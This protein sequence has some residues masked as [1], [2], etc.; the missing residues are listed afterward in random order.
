LTTTGELSG[1]LV[2][3]EAHII[4]RSP[5]GPRYETLAPEVRDGYDNLILLCANDHLEVDTQLTRYTVE[6]LRSIKHRHELWVKARLSVAPASDNGATVAV[7]MTSGSE[8]WALL[9]H[10]MAYQCGSPDDLTDEEAE[11]VD[12]ALQVFVDWAEIASDVVAEGFRAV[13]EAK[14]SIQAEFDAL[15]N[16]GF[17]L[18][19][20][21][22]KGAWSGG[23][24]TGKIAVLEVV[25]PA[26]LEALAV[27]APEASQ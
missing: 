8:I 27:Q 16:A 22:R 21:H 20:G 6:R 15:I 23:E 13:R 18:L 1:A 10:S 2:G 12:G 19:G 14:K 4:A 5:G 9:D 7:V 25:R 11:L 24:V 17:V 3:Q 26:D